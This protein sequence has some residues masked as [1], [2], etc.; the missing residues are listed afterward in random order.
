MG[1]GWILAGLLFVVNLGFLLLW[2]LFTYESGR[3]QEPR[4]PRFGWAG[5]GVH[6]LLAVLIL[7]WPPSRVPLAWLFGL[8]LAIGLFFLL[9]IPGKARS[10]RGAAGYLARDGTAFER[11]DERDSMFARNRSLRPGSP[12]HERY[13]AAHPEHLE[14]DEKRRARG[15]PLGR[16]GAIDGGYR[17]NVAMLLSSFELPN[18]VGDKARIDP[19]TAAS[20]SSYAGGEAPE[21]ENMDPEKAS[22]IVKGWARRLGADLV[23]ICRIDP[24]WA[25]SR[26][27]EIHYGEWD[28]WGRE[29]PAPLPYAVVIATEMDTDMVAAA[30]HTPSVVESALNYSRGAY[31]TTILAQWFGNLGYRSVAEHNR[32]Y[33]LLM[34]PLAVDAGLGELGRLGYLIADRFGPRVRLF[35]V[36]T[37][38]PLAVDRPVDLGA[39]TFC[40]A[41]KKCAESCPSRSLPLEREQKEDRG[42]VRWKMNE[43][44]CFDYW[45]KIGTDCCVCM[46]VCPFSRPYRSVHRLVRFV[47][48]RSLPAQRLFP[49]IDNLLYGRRWRPR[50]P[51]GWASYP[52]GR[53]AGG[54]A[55]LEGDR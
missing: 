44:T 48:R 27:G 42:I 2:A 53:T 14:Y 15:G 38:M 10:R 9:P 49:H 17:P 1:N 36:Q 41:C 43:E 8:L 28:Q 4:A 20:R 52:K 40:E 5:M 12:E 6:A 18:M 55:A 19:A 13:Y 25:Y 39:E 30:P 22:R 11:M 51:P 45:G 23:G 50:R 24:R 34:V 31:I 33:D 3:E 47:L 7:A 26:R 21:P 16:P 46:A 37:D 29:V 54:T 32:H 35:A